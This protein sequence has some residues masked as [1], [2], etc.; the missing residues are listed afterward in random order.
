MYNVKKTP[1]DDFC[2]AKG[3]F[4]CAKNRSSRNE[5][6]RRFLGCRTSSA[7]T[8]IQGHRLSSAFYRGLVKG[9]RFRFE[10]ASHRRQIR[11]SSH[12]FGPAGAFQGTRNGRFLQNVRRGTHPEPVHNVQHPREVCVACRRSGQSRSGAYRDRTLCTHREYPRLCKAHARP[13]TKRP[14]I[15]SVPRADRDTCTHRFSLGRFHFKG[16]DKGDRQNTRA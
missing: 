13:H 10:S 16:R 15:F 14:D 8:G 6:R 7:K 9:L 1:Q 3:A 12:F 11:N 2:G 5:R 4:Y